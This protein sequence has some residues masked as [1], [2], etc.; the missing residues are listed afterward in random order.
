[1]TEYQIAK[2]RQANDHFSRAWAL[3]APICEEL[4]GDFKQAEEAGNFIARAAFQEVTK[5]AIAAGRGIQAIHTLE[6]L[7]A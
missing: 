4:N 6:D 5:A 1:M 2:I 3:L 7:N